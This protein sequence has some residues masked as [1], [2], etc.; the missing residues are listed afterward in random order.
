MPAPEPKSRPVSGAWWKWP[1]IFVLALVWALTSL[2]AWLTGGAAK[3]AHFVAE[4]CLTGIE[5]L[6]DGG[7]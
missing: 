7:D 6:R 3:G 5:V 2:A 4:T 1:L